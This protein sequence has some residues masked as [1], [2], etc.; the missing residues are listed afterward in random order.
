ML[1]A[2]GCFSLILRQQLELVNLKSSLHFEQVLLLSFSSFHLPSIFFWSNFSLYR[3][4]IVL[5]QGASVEGI[6]KCNWQISYLNLA[7]FQMLWFHLVSVV[8]VSLCA[9]TR[10]SAWCGVRKP[11]K[12]PRNARVEMITQTAILVQMINCAV[13]PLGQP[14]HWTD[15]VEGV[16]WT[17]R[18][19]SVMSCSIAANQ[20]SMS[21]HVTSAL[22]IWSLFVW[23]ATIPA[24]T[25]APSLW[26]A[27]HAW[28][29]SWFSDLSFPEY[30]LPCVGHTTAHACQKNCQ[31]G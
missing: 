16:A 9:V 7:L 24:W 20:S 31:A 26:W 17:I 18:W 12:P 27:S 1:Q 6:A 29:P 11:P 10:L 2:H 15:P 8:F 30:P 13:S 23:Q 25:T 5:A 28:K 3:V 14:P 4:R 21:L 19:V 22:A